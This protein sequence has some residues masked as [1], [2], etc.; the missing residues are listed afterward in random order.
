MVSWL[1]GSGR[2]RPACQHALRGCMRV[3]L[4]LE[5]VLRS[6]QPCGLLL[7]GSQVVMFQGVGVQASACGV[8]AQCPANKLQ[9]SGIRTLH[10]AG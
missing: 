10:S 6:Q 2:R 4:R 5:K 8:R 7:V 3:F 1:Q 9:R